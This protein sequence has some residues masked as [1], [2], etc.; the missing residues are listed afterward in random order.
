[1]NQTKFTVFVENVKEKEVKKR[2]RA[3][4]RNI[5]KQTFDIQYNRF[6]ARY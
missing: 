5:E 4:K 3:K 1:M 2:K 6:F